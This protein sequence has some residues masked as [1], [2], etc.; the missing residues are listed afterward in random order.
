[1]LAFKYFREEYESYLDFLLGDDRLLM[2][3]RLTRIGG[4]YY[5]ESI[6]R[7]IV[8]NRIVDPEM[9]NGIASRDEILKDKLLISLI[10]NPK[11]LWKYLNVRVRNAW[12][13]R[14]ILAQRLKTYLSEQGRLND[15]EGE[16]FREYFI[17]I[18]SKVGFTGMYWSVLKGF[19]LAE[20][21]VCKN[22]SALSRSLKSL[23]RNAFRTYFYGEFS[24]ETSSNSKSKSKTGTSKGRVKIRSL[25]DF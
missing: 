23:H 2:K 21:N 25:D 18:M 13:S 5:M 4:T 19:M 14:V 3:H 24:P 7:Q 9:M 16:D 8:E 20:A 12:I 6:L 1:M 11:K 10:E 22:W 15:L 17:E